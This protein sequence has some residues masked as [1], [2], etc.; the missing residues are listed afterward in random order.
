MITSTN[1]SVPHIKEIISF[2][3]IRYSG[4]LFTVVTVVII[5]YILFVELS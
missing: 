2:S 1:K 4:L 5:S 3:I